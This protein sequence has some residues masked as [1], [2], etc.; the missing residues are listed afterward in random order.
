MTD[1]NK[2]SEQMID[3]AERLADV[4][5][6]AQGKGIRRGSTGTRW[7]LLPMAGAA[8]YALATS[9]S[10]ARRTKSAVQ[11]AKSRATDLPEDLLNRVRQTS[12]TTNQSKS[13]SRGQSR[14]RT[15]PS[16]SGRRTSSSRRRSSARKSASAR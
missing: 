2:L 5:D 8:I 15:A 3:Y 13:R 1:I 12:T 9:D 10:L 11:Q 7:V 6:A 16:S 4:S 14:S